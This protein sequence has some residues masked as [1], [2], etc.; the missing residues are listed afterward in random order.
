ML[1]LIIGLLFSLGSINALIPII[2]ILILLVAAAGLNRGYNMFNFFGLTTLAGINP[3]GKASPAGKTGFN[4]PAG[5]IRPAGRVGDT[6]KIGKRT[7][8]GAIKLANRARARRIINRGGAPTRWQKAKAEHPAVGRFAVAG[9]AVFMDKPSTTAKNIVN[10]AVAA[11]PTSRLGKT[12]VKPFK[13]AHNFRAERLKKLKENPIKYKEKT[14]RKAHRKRIW[15]EIW[16]EAGPPLTTLAAFAWPLGWGV[17]RAR[18][19]LRNREESRKRIE[20]SA[21]QGKGAF[22]A[23]KQARDEFLGSRSVRDLSPE[24]KRK[25]NRQMNEELNEQYHPG[26]HTLVGAAGAAVG[27]GRRAWRKARKEGASLGG[28]AGAVVGKAKEGAKTVGTHQGT[29]VDE[30]TGKPKRWQTSQEDAVALRGFLDLAFLVRAG[31]V[32]P[33]KALKVSIDDPKV[34]STSREADVLLGARAAYADTSHNGRRL[35]ILQK[36]QLDELAS[37]G[38]PRVA[39]TEGAIPSPAQVKGT[40]AAAAAT[41]PAGSTGAAE[42]VG[43]KPV[44]APDSSDDPSHKKK[45]IDNVVKGLHNPNATEGMLRDGAAHSEPEIAAAALAHPNCPPEV[46]KAH[47]NDSDKRVADAAREPTHL[48]DA[49]GK[50]VKPKPPP[51]S[52]DD[53]EMLEKRAREREEEAR[54]EGN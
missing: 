31:G 16:K 1:V 44:L 9:R 19:G 28:A 38:S 15:E 49:K 37:R 22:G 42:T 21:K 45:L 18:E 12:V 52:S 11:E 4:F 39:A 6:L 51:A 8:S 20:D 34:V 25:L 53:L 7:Y 10:Y 50:P 26:P 35:E 5:I 2:I 29:I 36:T 54:R 14:D 17:H 47:E 30:V 46:R 3:G 40:A 48:E 41:K 32:S 24:E 13:R 33:S 27:S 23:A 43:S